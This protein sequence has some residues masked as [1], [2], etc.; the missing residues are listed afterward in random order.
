MTESQAIAVRGNLDVA[1]LDELDQIL[2]TG[3]YESEIIDDPAEISRQIV[4]Q[5]LAAEDD[6]QVFDFGNAVGWREFVGTPMEVR[7]FHWR[8][9]AY[10]AGAPIYFVVRAVRLDTGEIVTLTTGSHNVL[11]QLSNLARRGRIP[12]I[13]VALEPAKNPTAAGFTP[14]RLVKVADSAADYVKAASK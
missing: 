1:S 3:E 9:S 5:L 4:A 12:G 11:A 13:V 7:G 10:E 8:P 6:S 2:L 14:L